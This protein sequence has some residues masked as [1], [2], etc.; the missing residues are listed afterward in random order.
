MIIPIQFWGLNFNEITITEPGLTGALLFTFRIA[1]TVSLM[2]LL[3]LT[4][5]WMDLL[6]ASTRIRDSSNV[7]NDSKYDLP[8]YFFN[9]PSG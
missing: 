4:T 7:Y 2:V 8:V 9:G 5:H 3:T 6:K 1:T